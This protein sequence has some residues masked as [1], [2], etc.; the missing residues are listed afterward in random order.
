MNGYRA[1]C[2]GDS[3]SPL[4]YN[5]VQIGIAAYMQLRCTPGSIDVYTMVSP[6]VPWI[7]SISG[8]ITTIEINGSNPINHV[9]IW[10]LLSLTMLT[11]LSYSYSLSY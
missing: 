6:F 4:I 9:N 2:F 1:L 11:L 7:Q 8:P 10:I 3:G 5:N